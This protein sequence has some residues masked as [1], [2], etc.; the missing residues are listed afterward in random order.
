VPPDQKVNKAEE[1]NYLSMS[2]DLVKKSSKFS[3]KYMDS[4]VSPYFFPALVVSELL[5]ILQVFIK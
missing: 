5:A 3:K 4:K 1:L 2:I